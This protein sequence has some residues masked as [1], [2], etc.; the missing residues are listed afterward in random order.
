MNYHL[1][2]KKLGTAMMPSRKK[3]FKDMSKTTERL[4][5][6]STCGLPLIHSLQTLDVTGSLDFQSFNPAEVYDPTS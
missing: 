2:W 5:R 3:S 6:R 4:E 1:S